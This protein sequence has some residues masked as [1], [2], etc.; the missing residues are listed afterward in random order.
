MSLSVSRRSVSG[1]CFA[2]VFVEKCLPPFNSKFVERDGQIGTVGDWKATG[3]IDRLSD[4]M[5][6]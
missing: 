3:T 1:K 2:S 6:C 4:T 5:L